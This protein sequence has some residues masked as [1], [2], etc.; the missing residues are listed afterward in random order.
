MNRRMLMGGFFWFL[1][2]LFVLSGAAFAAHPLLTDDTGT[3]GA[4]NFQ[5]EAT[6][7]WLSDQED[8]AG[9]GVREVSSIAALV[10]TA[11]IAETLDVIVEVPYVWTETKEA[12]QITKND[13][14][15]DTIVAAKWR[16]YDKQKFSLAIKPSILLPTGDEDEG[17]GT[18]KIGYSGTF[19]STLETEHWAFDL[20]LAYLHVEN[21]LD[22]RANIWYGSLATRFT[23]D[24]A[25][26]LV[27]EVGA[28]RNA[29]RTD[30][31]HPAFAQIGLIYSPTENLDLSV[32]FLAGLSDSEIDQA[33]RAGT[34]IRF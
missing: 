20:H 12:G 29:D 22:E 5:L 8:E 13:G 33:L 21:E 4:G 6:G 32:G 24:E 2:L 23:V 11:G 34:T 9:E 1:Y 16:F 3:Q 31:S 25:W 26:T 15:F 17:L 10:F 7:T 30:S 14:F 19:I 28:T 27:G 18:G